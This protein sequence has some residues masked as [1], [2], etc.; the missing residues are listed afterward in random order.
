MLGTALVLG[1]CSAIKL[2]YN[3]SATFAHT[4]L[5]SKVDFDSDQ[6]ALMKTSLRG[7]VEWHRNNELPLLAEELQKARMV[8]APKGE[9]IQPVNASQVNALNQAIRTSLRR[10]A[11]EAAPV[12]AKNMLGLWPNQVADIQEALDKSNREYREKRM[13]SNAAER[14]EKSV[15]RMAERFERWLGDLNPKQMERIEQWAKSAA[16]NPEQNYEKRL[17]RQQVFMQLVRQSANR[18]IDQATL[19]R[20]VSQLLNDWQTPGTSSER[21][22]FELRQQAVIELV[23]DVLNAANMQQRK[24]AAERAASWAEDF[25]ILASKQ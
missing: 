20:E 23:V 22:D 3:N 11:D 21:K 4:Y 13:A 5:T 8:L 18:Q 24:N 12:I 25:Q 14:T 17:K 2:G 7:L 15:E 10:T 9:N 6:S 19:T 16:N 1:A